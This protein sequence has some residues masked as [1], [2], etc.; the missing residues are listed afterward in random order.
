MRP[1]VVSLRRAC[2]EKEQ[3]ADSVSHRGKRERRRFRLAVRHRYVAWAGVVACFGFLVIS[4]L[5]FIGGIQE[6]RISSASV[7]WPTVQAEITRIVQ[8]KTFPQPRREIT[9]AAYERETSVKYTVNG[10]QYT[11]DFRLPVGSSN[12]AAD[13]RDSEMGSEGHIDRLTVYYNP[14]NPRE[15]VLYPGNYAVA[16]R[17]V[18]VGGM[19]TLICSMLVLLLVSKLSTPRV[20][21]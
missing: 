1:R 13:P 21:S 16:V 7:N 11:T 8:A 3:G 20:H 18:A 12:E 15:V 14:G 9:S 5:I 10:T 19:G 17:G 6:W 2:V 4:I